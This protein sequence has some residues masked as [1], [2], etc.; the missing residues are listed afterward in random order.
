MI[1]KFEVLSG[2]TI[3]IDLSRC[4]ECVSKACVKACSRPGMGQILELKDGVPSLK[5]TPEE[6]KKGACTECLGCELDCSLHG[7]NAVTITLPLGDLDC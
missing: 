3:E 5:C 7:N 2:G 4:K 6:A 1:L